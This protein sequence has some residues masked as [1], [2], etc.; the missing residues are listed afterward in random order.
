MPKILVIDDDRE[1]AGMVEDWLLYEKHD[2][3]VVHTGFE[4]WKEL[5]AGDFDLALCDWDL[6]DLNG[7]DIVKRVRA[8]GG[9]TPII[10]LTGHT[11]IEDKEQGLDS[12]ANDYL[13]KPFHMKELSARVRA[14]LRNS[15]PMAPVIKALGSDNEEILRRGDLL[16]TSLPGRYE[17]LEIIGEGGIGLVFKA[18]H[19]HLEKLFAIK[20][21]LASEMSDEMVSRFHLEA[22]AISKLDH[23]NIIS[24]HDFGITEKRQPFMVMDYIA[25]TSL[26]TAILERDYIPVAEALDYLIG[27]ADGIAHAHDE[28]I[29]HRDIKP[30]NVMLK[31][32]SD[33]R[34][35]P[36]L[37]DFG[38]A[39][40]QQA[41]HK[42]I[43]TTTIHQVVGSPPYMSPEQVRGKPLDARSDIYALGCMMFELLTG[44]LPHAGDTAV[45]LMFKHL[46][47]PPLTFVE[48]RPK[49]SFP[50]GLQEAVNRA[51]QKQPEQRFQTMHE[52]RDE[53]Q[54]IRKRI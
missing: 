8:S 14:V 25:G 38:L 22:K 12:G 52:L 41:G 40:V 44:Y 42:P 1:L 53:L 7:I 13:T 19:P 4:G 16:G 35:V 9:S 34:V 28:A 36:K 47:E 39:K 23:P 15:S 51:M 24:V 2:V 48:V 32:M 37:L 45:E 21:L 30:A 6:P 31:V 3:H 49:L 5:Q 33:G 46:E 26:E 27:L 29:L 43:H 20:M 50:D 10:M 18:R 54:N 11:S 17:F